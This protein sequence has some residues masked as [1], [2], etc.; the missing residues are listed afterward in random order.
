MN[1][2]QG[3]KYL[4]VFLGLPWCVWLRPTKATFFWPWSAEAFAQA[5]VPTPPAAMFSLSEK[6]DALF[7]QGKYDEALV[8]YLQ[9]LNTPQSSPKEQAIANCRAGIVHSIHSKNSLARSYIEKSIAITT[10]PRK[11]ESVCL[12]ALLQVYVIESENGLAQ[13]LILRMGELELPD[14]YIARSLALGIEVGE[15]LQNRDLLKRNADRLIAFM[16]LKKIPVVEVKVLGK[17]FTK[18]SILQILSKVQSK[19]VTAAVSADKS[20]LAP[21]AG[22]LQNQGSAQVNTNA[23]GFVKA[24]HELAEGKG[25]AQISQFKG[26]VQNPQTAEMLSQSG[27]SLGVAKIAERLEHLSKDAPKVMR[28]GVVV[29]SGVSFSRFKHK[30]LRAI[31]AFAASSATKGVEYSFIVKAVSSDP[32]SVEENVLSLLLDEHVHAILGPLTSSQAMA[33]LPLCE[34]LAVPLFSYGPVT[35]SSELSS[36]ALIRMGVLAKS[37]AKAHLESLRKSPHIKRFSVLAPNDPY[38]IE[39]AQGFADVVN[40]KGFSMHRVTYFDMDKEV[41]SDPVS[42][43]LGPQGREA[44]G[45]EFAEAE[46]E[47][48]AK[49]AAEKRKFDPSQI[50]IPAKIHFDALFLPDTLSRAKVIASTFAF[51]DA[52]SVRYLG[53]R[54]WAEVSSKPTLAD[55]YLNGARIP[56]PD[57]GP[58]LSYLRRTLHVASGVL[59]LESQ[60]F[61]SLVLLRQAQFKSSGNDGHKLMEAMRA[62]EFKV[63][64][65]SK[66]GAIDFKGEPEVTMSMWNYRNG[67]ASP[68]LLTWK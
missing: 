33:A 40:E 6:A 2:Q 64:G 60:V 20:P 12:Y 15:R 62:K 45:P 11:V 54:T 43:V 29:P 18:E 32:G 9:V 42:M 23:L 4:I 5:P 53:D 66:M 49:A 31:S 52:K 48:R 16:E 63:Q 37:Q 67:K 44:R 57:L 36:A 13:N 61:D 39:M 24:F 14:S 17:Q 27:L 47:L 28:V 38:G 3:T 56:V 30:M 41:F 26:Q 1:L 21:A 68:D 7:T 65:A 34:T 59:D 46:K 25:F 8:T 55:E 58:F 10:L 35:W 22:Q 51:Q 50:K 19:N